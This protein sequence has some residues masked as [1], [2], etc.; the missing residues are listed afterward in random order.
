MS[1][2]KTSCDVFA[3]RGDP[4]ATDREGRA[5]YGRNLLSENP[6]VDSLLFAS[7]VKEVK[8]NFLAGV[9]IVPRKSTEDKPDNAR[10][11]ANALIR[12]NRAILEE[13]ENAH[14]K[15]IQREDARR[16]NADGVDP[17]V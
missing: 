5:K 14:A 17:K 10:L 1:K 11:K 2:I 13:K 4:W 3:Q 16:R 12:I 15:R 6:E 9:R 7:R 8:G